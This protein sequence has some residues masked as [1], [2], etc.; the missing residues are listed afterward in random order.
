MVVA[1]I[2]TTCNDITDCSNGSTEKDTEGKSKYGNITIRGDKLNEYIRGSGIAYLATNIYKCNNYG[3]LDIGGTQTHED[4]NFTAGGIFSLATYLNTVADCKN[5]GDIELSGYSNKNGHVAGIGVTINENII[6]LSNVY[7]YGNITYSATG[8]KA[9]NY[10]GGILN[11]TSK[12]ELH[13]AYNYGNVTVDGT[14][15]TGLYL[16]GIVGRLNSVGKFSGD[17]INEGV[18]RMGANAS[19]TGSGKCAYVGGL[20]GGCN[21]AVRDITGDNIYSRGPIIV[22]EGANAAGG[23][24]IGGVIGSLVEATTHNPKIIGVKSACEIEAI[25]RNNIGMIIGT[26]RDANNPKVK[27]CRV[28]GTICASKSGEGEAERY[29]LQILDATNYHKY[30]YGSGAG[31]D[32]TGAIQHD[33]NIFDSSLEP[34]PMPEE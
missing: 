28:N 10:I 4:G 6:T 33:G 2:S 13:N 8:S 23:I 16:G 32:W 21:T 1:G 17:I 14:T 15:A 18:V 9:A 31:T 20:F 12:T 7:N 3:K 27:D 5:Y 11:T 30:I 19:V 29:N 22:E 25:G 24:Y 26:A 34:K